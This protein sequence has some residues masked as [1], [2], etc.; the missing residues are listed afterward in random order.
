MSTVTNPPHPPRRR[1]FAA[2][3]AALAAALQWRLLLLWLLC[4][5]LPAALATLPLWTTL[6]ATFGH[7]VHAGDIAAGRNV[8]LLLHG[9]GLLGEHGG[10]A[11]AIGTLAA[12]ALMLLLSPFL[13]GMVVASLRAG[14]RLGFGELVGGGCAEYWRMLRMLL[15]SVLPLGVAL[16]IGGAAFAIASHATDAAILPS[17][18]T[19]ASRI[20]LAVAVV[21]FVL[22]HASVEAGRGW[23]GADAGLRSVVRAWWRGLRTRRPLA[24]LGIYL[25]ATVPALLLALLFA[26]LRVRLDGV[27]GAAFAAGFLLTQAIAL[28]LAWG[29]IARL[30]GLAGLAADTAA[31]AVR[32]ERR[33]A[34]TDDATPPLAPA[35]SPST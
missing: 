30:Y 23:L 11:I 7:S 24:T 17:E 2:L 9:L 15:W 18:V 16:A 34:T 35:P 29:R 5:L 3:G 20:A 25:G 32:P 21:A 28:A 1:G 14:R 12:S 13:T 33:I 22:L 8:G 10:G 4:T 19:R 31:R 6:Q 26:W 27:G